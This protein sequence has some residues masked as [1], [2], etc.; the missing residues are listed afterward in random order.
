MTEKQKT[1]ICILHFKIY[2]LLYYLQCS[3]SAGLVKVLLFIQND[4][5]ITIVDKNNQKQVVPIA[6]CR[7]ILSFQ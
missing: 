7:V 3:V 4:Q 2:C 1:D 5:I 6:T